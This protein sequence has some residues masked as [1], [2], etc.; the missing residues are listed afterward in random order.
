MNKIHLEIGSL[1]SIKW[2]DKN[3]LF[4]KMCDAIFKINEKHVG[5]IC[6]YVKM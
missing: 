1:E 3:C 5:K 2:N 4:E 6:I